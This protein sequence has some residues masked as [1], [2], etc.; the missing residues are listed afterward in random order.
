[1]NKTLKVFL[2]VIC[3]LAVLAAVIVPLVLN[4]NAI[5]GTIKGEAY[6]TYENV[7]ESYNKGFNEGSA[8]LNEFK[9]QLDDLKKQ[10][11]S[12]IKTV[13][14]LNEQVSQLTQANSELTSNKTENEKTI[15]ELNSTISNLNSEINTLT[16]EIARLN[17]LLKAYQAYEGQTFEVVFYV[18]D[19]AVSAKVVKIGEVVTQD[20]IPTKTGT[21]KYTFKG[22]SI[23]RVSVVNLS[24]YQITEDTNFY[25]VFEESY[26]S[27]LEFDENSDIKTYSISTPEEL[28]KFSDLS[29]SFAFEG[30]TI[31][32]TATIDMKNENFSPIANSDNIYFK[33]TFNGN[34]FEIK[35]LT[36]ETTARRN[37]LF[38]RTFNANLLNIRLIDCNIRTTSGQGNTAG[39][40]SYC[41]ADS[42]SVIENIYI[43]GN[44]YGDMTVGALIGNAYGYALTISNVTLNC[45]V[46]SA[47]NSSYASSNSYVGAIFGRLGYLNTKINNINYTGN[48]TIDGTVSLSGAMIGFVSYKSSADC[49]LNVKDFNVNVNVSSDSKL[50]PIAGYVSDGASNIKF[51][52]GTI[53]Y[54]GDVDTSNLSQL[55]T[56]SGVNI[57]NN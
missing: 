53:I 39:L 30:Y 35:N 27:I 20:Y 44:I 23:D 56:L 17:E 24:S 41:I 38:G 46:T 11:D 21:I 7:Q 55:I 19:T 12:K 31:M 2:I 48:L 14:E 42:D 57:T 8:N 4:W 5:T 15:S 34:N 52:N 47:P 33:G 10:L 29:Q 13:N 40:V 9:T 32:Q 16:S 43:S 22:W 1:M 6:Y 50:S 36:S 28:N 3:C 51:S 26:Y 18:D 37:A 45:N 49:S 25:A 54:S